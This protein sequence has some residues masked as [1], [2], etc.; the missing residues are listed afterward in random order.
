MAVATP[1]ELITLLEREAAAERAQVLAD[2]QAQAAAIRDGARGEAEAYL[3]TARARME[4]EA[5]AALVKAQSTAQLRAASMVLQAKEEEIARV[6]AR[7]EEELAKVARDAERYP[8][9]LRAFIEEGLQGVA[10]P[11]VATVNPGDVAAAEAVARGRAEVTVRADPAVQGGVR[12]ATPDGRFVVTNTLA[13]R[14]DRARPTL[15]AEVAKI[16]WG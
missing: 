14:L 12:V 1:S 9:V 6:F 3:A 13:S 15:A 8:A 10:G 4:A 7:A 5:R 16:L 11:A 2:A